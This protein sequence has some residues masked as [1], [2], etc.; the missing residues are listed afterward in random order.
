MT[1][2]FLNLF[3]HELRMQL[4]SPATYVS[5]ALF[6]ALMGLIHWLAISQAAVDSG[7]W[8]PSENIFRL[9]WVP[10]LAFIPLLTMGAF[11][12]ERRMGT[13]A[14]LLTTPV[15][16]HTVTLAKFAAA[17]VRYLLLWAGAMAFPVIANATL[18]GSSA[19]PR[20]LGA[21][22]LAGGFA[23]V[24]A[25]SLCYVAIGLLCSSMTRSLL[26]AGMTTFVAIATLLFAHHGLHLLATTYDVPALLAP[27][28]LMNAA[29]YAEDF[30][31]GV[32][33]TR[34]FLHFGSVAILALGATALVV[35][36]K[37]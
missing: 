34:P 9:H 23:F 5:A 11:A 27:A 10:A 1:R 29:K 8:L 17:Y 37:A 16:P 3:F 36:T 32:I 31:R 24:A 30:A 21:S 26:V 13:L 28:E 20:L 18:P 19:D 25:S 6:L 12:E 7:D 22:S 2:R 4:V 14:A 35:E 33:D 15:G